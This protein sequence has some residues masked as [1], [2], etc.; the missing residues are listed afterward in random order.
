MWRMFGRWTSG[1]LLHRRRVSSALPSC[2]WVGVGRCAHQLVLWAWEDLTLVASVVLAWQLSDG[3]PG[4]DNC[5]FSLTFTLGL[6][7]IPAHPPFV[8]PELIKTKEKHE[9]VKIHSSDMLWISDGSERDC[10]CSISMVQLGPRLRTERDSW[11]NSEK[12]P[13]KIGW[14][15]VVK[16]SLLLAPKVLLDNLWPMIIIQPI[17]SISI[18]M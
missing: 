14:L 8:H 10:C 16:I 18:H 11:G 4:Q 12:F 7:L 5:L 2:P 1:N 13:G 6:I 17:P 9:T 15:R 3:A